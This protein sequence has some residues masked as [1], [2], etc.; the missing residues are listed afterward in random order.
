MLTVDLLVCVINTDHGGVS[1]EI[2]VENQYH[3]CEA[4]LKQA[5]IKYG[6][7]DRFLPGLSLG[8]QKMVISHILQSHGHCIYHQ[9][10]RC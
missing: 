7:G 4:N 8:C 10:V 6:Q 3:N 9:A 2:Q 1:P 5:L